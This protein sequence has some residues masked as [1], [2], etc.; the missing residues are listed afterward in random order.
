MF[1]KPVK[2]TTFKFEKLFGRPVVVEWE[3]AASYN[4]WHSEEDVKVAS[5]DRHTCLTYG[6]LHPSSN[7]ERLVL[8][9]THPPGRLAP[10]GCLWTIPWGMISKVKELR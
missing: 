1:K 2:K 9:Q 5:V 3:D 8:V 6:L 4:A 10:A 7:N